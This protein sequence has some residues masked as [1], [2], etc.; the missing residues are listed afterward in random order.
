MTMEQLLDL[1][2][3]VARKHAS[4]AGLKQEDAK[5]LTD[6][7]FKELTDRIVKVAAANTLPT[8]FLVATAKALALLIV[9]SAR[10]GD[11]TPDELLKFIQ[12]AVLQFAAEAMKEMDAQ[13]PPPLPSP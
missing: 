3:D 9:Y 5:E 2:F 1:G 7:Q 13:T 11:K 4:A 8:D 6:Y 10:R 12:D